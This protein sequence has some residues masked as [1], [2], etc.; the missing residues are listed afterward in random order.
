M[1]VLIVEDETIVA[2]DLRERLRCLGYEPCGIADSPDKAFALARDTQP[3]LVL[4]DIMLK[5]DGDG[6][7]AAARIRAAMDVPII[8]VTA[9]SDEE[10]LERVKATSP[11]GYIVKPY[12]ERELRIA[13]ELAVAKHQSELELLR[14]KRAA[15]E[16]DRAKTRFLANLSHEFITPINSML[17]FIELA[18][19]MS[20]D[21]ELA[22][23]LGLIA[24]SAH[25]LENL[26]RSLLDFA[27]LESGS[28]S[29]VKS[30]FYLEDFLL[31]CW[32]P[33]QVEA[34][35]KGLA[36]RYFMD[37]DLPRSFRGDSAKI[38]L[39][40]RALVDNAVKF[41]SSGSVLLSAEREDERLLI[42]VSDTGPG[43]PAEDAERVFGT[44]VQ[45]DDSPTRK[46][47]GL[48]LGL[49]L[50]RGLA[51][52]LGAELRLEGY[53]GGVTMSL[54]LAEPTD[55]RGPSVRDEV[56]PTLRGLKLG[57]ADPP[58]RCAPELRRWGEALGFSVV[59]AGDGG[60]CELVVAEL[61]ALHD[62]PPGGRPCL[63]LG[64]PVEPTAVR[65]SAACPDVPV[66]VRPYPL[67]L[68]AL[69]D[70]IRSALG[71]SAETEARRRP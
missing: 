64:S 65:G 8:F 36:P 7:S 54:R 11:Y 39:I 71:G 28:L 35:A 57:L 13:I 32:A 20:A 24:S 38:G 44:F 19:S 37:P 10:T 63:A 68:Y 33:F 5:G 30:E 49:A 46:A 43:I 27:K 50:S 23:Y 41:T 16:S 60:A 12:H 70:S 62:G 1:R 51:A 26:V 4:M 67:G 66:C 17:G 52:L 21:A 18:G 58:P 15:E 42:R 6:V 34:Y 2:L 53:S 40:V 25:R 22:E 47:G 69:S 59:P 55:G 61:A 29:V 9:F 14:A 31:S 3:Q 45:G 56:G 48:G